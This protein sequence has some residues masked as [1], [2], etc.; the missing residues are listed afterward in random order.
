VVEDEPDH[1]L[2]RSEDAGCDLYISHGMT[3][4]VGSQTAVAVRP[5]KIILGKEPPADAIADGRN[6]A[7]GVVQQIAYMGDASIYLIKLDSGKTV[8]VTAP[9]LTR[10]V[11]MPITWEDRVYLSW[12][13]Y[14]G[15]VLSQ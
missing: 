5:E 2:V 11:D 4:P 12:R 7:V 9:N 10:R 8:R 13:P 3:S 14:A 15:V 1:V 6:L